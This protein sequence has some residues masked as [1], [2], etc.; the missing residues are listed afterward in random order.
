MK[1]L[2]LIYKRN[3]RIIYMKRKYKFKN[4]NAKASTFMSLIW[5]RCPHINNWATKSNISVVVTFLIQS[6]RSVQS[7]FRYNQN[8]ELYMDIKLHSGEI[9]S[10][11]YFHCRHNYH[12]H[13]NDIRNLHTCSSSKKSTACWC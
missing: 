1:F 12:V 3:C 8:T 11:A 2:H 4:L 5:I 10:F 13:K 7:N 9:K 6:R